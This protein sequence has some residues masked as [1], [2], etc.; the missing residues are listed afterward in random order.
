MAAAAPHVS[1]YARLINTTWQF[2]EAS[3]R[4]AAFPDDANADLAAYTKRLSGATRARM[5]F[6][7]GGD[8]KFEVTRPDGCAM[9][10]VASASLQ[11]GNWGVGACDLT[12]GFPEVVTG[13]NP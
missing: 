12:P 8:G 5:T 3:G 6:R 10:G 13:E 11:A 9:R 4:A 1:P 2:V 7:I